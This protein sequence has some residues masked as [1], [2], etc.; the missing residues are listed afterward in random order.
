MY[1]GTLRP[2]WVEIDLAAL[3]YNVKQIKAKLNNNTKIIGVVKA[4]AYGHG[5]FE[6]SDVLK[7]NGVD[8]F[9]VATLAEGIKLREYF[10]EDYASGYTVGTY[11]GMLYRDDEWDCPDGCFVSEA[12][13]ENSADIG[14]SED[15]SDELISEADILPAE[16]IIILGLVPDMYAD[17]VVQ[18]DLVPVVCDYENALA[19]SDAAAA[20]GKTVSILIAIDTGMGRIGYMT[21]TADDISNAVNEVLKIKELPNLRITGVISHMSTADE[22]DKGFARM[23]EKKYDAFC[24]ALFEAGVCQSGES[25][26]HCIR[27]F[28]NSAAVMELESTHHEAVRPG[29]ILY[30]CYP[31]SEVDKNA[32]SL[33][34]VMS[35]KANIVHLKEVPAGFSVGYGRRYISDKSAKIATVS[36][37]Y[38]DGY[39]RRYS[40]ETPSSEAVNAEFNKPAGPHVIVNGVYAPLAGKICMDQCMIDV[41]DVPNVK[42][43]D[44]VI[45][46][47]SMPSAYG[48]I[49]NTCESCTEVCSDDDSEKPCGDTLLTITADDIANATGTISYEILCGFGTRLPKVYKYFK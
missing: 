2:A 35:V 25:G 36:L 27:T 5:A 18:Y 8:S 15:G 14:L 28:A 9:A 34:P 16:E 29:I 6:V 45:V 17:T 4:D 38:A 39:P 31:S 23:Q 44:E 13:S 30:G 43:G 10:D 3:D 42:V 21:E 1:K 33:K 49:A 22:A 12:A 47:G 7:K 41:T 19:F 46:M 11:D 32:L 40:T 37:G 48:K 26:A 24:S 20:A